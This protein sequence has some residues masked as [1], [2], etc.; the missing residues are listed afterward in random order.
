M[1]K[2]LSKRAWK[3]ISTATAFVWSSGRTAPSLICLLPILKS[4]CGF[5]HPVDAGLNCAR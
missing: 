4:N 3:S 2:N 5:P 1:Q